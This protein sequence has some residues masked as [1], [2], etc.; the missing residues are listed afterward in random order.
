MRTLLIL[1]SL[2]LLFGCRS[3]PAPVIVSETRS[4]E[5]VMEY[6]IQ[7]TESRQ[8]VPVNVD[9]RNVVAK[10]ETKTGAKAWVVDKQRWNPFNEVQV[11]KNEQAKT[12]ELKIAQ[13]KVPWWKWPVTV[14][15]FLAVLATVIFLDKIR[16][17]IF[18]WRRS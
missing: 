2:V 9:P 8:D 15:I 18:F 12:E 16:K 7:Q 6:E 5:Q 1:S 14:L 4:G 13:P 11:F 17:I 3:M 10:V